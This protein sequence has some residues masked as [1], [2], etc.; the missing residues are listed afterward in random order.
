MKSSGL[1]V[2]LVAS[3]LA[4]SSP[5]FAVDTAKTYHSSVLVL[6]FLGF[7][8]LIVVVQLVPSILMLLGWIKSLAKGTAKEEAKRS[9][10]G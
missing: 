4:V 3:W 8:A 2:S 7:L 6:V 10:A 1:I 5:A 9:Q